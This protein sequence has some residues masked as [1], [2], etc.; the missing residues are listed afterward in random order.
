MRVSETNKQDL[1]GFARRG[2]RTKYFKIVA[3]HIKN[4]RIYR[5]CY[6][7]WNVVFLFYVS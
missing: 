5:K 3:E 7:N 4:R 6:K 2:G 1:R